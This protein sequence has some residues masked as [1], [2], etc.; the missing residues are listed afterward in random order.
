MKKYF[1]FLIT[2]SS[3]PMF[4]QDGIQ[5][6]K[7]NWQEA[8]EFAKKEH[9]Y[10]FMDAYAEWCGPCKRMAR[11]VFTQKELGDFFNK[12]FINVKMDMEKGE[13][14][15]LASKYKVTAYPTLYFI[16]G[17]GEIINQKVG[18][19]NGEQLLGLAKASLAKGDKSKDYEEEYNNGNRNP[20]MLKAYAYA[21]MVSGQPTLKIA[22]EYIKSSG[23]S[24]S[25]DFLEFVFDFSSEADCSV[26]DILIEKR[27]KLIKL[28]GVEV[29]KAKVQKAC[30]ATVDKSVQFETPSLL[31]EA[32]SQ[33]KKALPP[34]AAEYSVLADIRYFIKTENKTKAAKVISTYVLK[35]AKNDPSKLH[36]AA[37]S[38]NQSINDK[39][40]LSNAEKWALK[41]YSLNKNLIFGR[42][43]GELLKKNG[44][45]EEL[46]KLFEELKTLPKE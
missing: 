16:D 3:L 20:D 7:G 44:K 12:H 29:F 31:K 8:L 10:I 23:I 5:F 2:L 34:F 42:T 40:M 28:K 17:E 18:G 27:E 33:M 41:A 32:K 26:F 15:K 21:L 24:D 36:F 25:E 1:F 6:F 45:V 22:N 46:K 38:V 35:F 39:K 14:P 11:E 43:Y 19:M 13:G 37:L 9:K 30:D 4:A